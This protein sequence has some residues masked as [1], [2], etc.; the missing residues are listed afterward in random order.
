MGG[1]DDGNMLKRIAQ[2]NLTNSIGTIAPLAGGINSSITGSG[3]LIGCQGDIVEDNG[4]LYVL[5]GFDQSIDASGNNVPGTFGYTVWDGSIWE[6]NT[7]LSSPVSFH[8]ADVVNGYVYIVG[9]F[10]EIDSPPTPYGVGVIYDPVSCLL[11]TSPSP[12][13]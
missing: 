9:F 10:S 3:C 7:S 8:D 12:R 1:F 4:K 11:Y 13:D 2:Y 6:Q 5:D